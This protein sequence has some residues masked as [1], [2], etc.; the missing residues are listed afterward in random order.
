MPLRHLAYSLY[1]CNSNMF[2]LLATARH[3][4]TNA[5]A[6]DA[7]QRSPIALPPAKKL[8]ILTCM[9]AR[10]N[11]FQQLDLKL[12]DAH[13]IRNAG[14]MARDALRSLIISQRLLGTREIAVYHHTGCGMATFSTPALRQLV[15]DSDPLNEDLGGMMDEID[16]MDWPEVNVAASG[17]NLAISGVQETSTTTATK[18]QSTPAGDV[19]MRTPTEPETKMDL[20]PG[21]NVSDPLVARLLESVKSDVKFLKTNPLLMKGTKVTG[22]VH[23]IETGNATRIV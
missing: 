22:W 3:C 21:T 9:D 14:G 7:A 20:P 18:V 13:I 16:F 6:V 11:P 5:P 4:S 23:W 19:L 10:I 15:A 1:A 17:P 8:A 2:N 12:G